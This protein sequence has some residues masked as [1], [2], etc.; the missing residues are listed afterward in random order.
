MTQMLI[1]VD[2]GD[3]NVILWQNLLPS[4]TFQTRLQNQEALL[5][6]YFLGYRLPLIPFQYLTI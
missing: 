2:N 5:K 6:R 3:Q 1:S 4:S